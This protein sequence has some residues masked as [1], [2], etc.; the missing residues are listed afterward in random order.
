MRAKRD[1]V[2]NCD[3]SDPVKSLNSARGQRTKRA[4]RCFI[5]TLCNRIFM[6]EQDAAAGLPKPKMFSVLGPGLTTGASDDDPSG[7]AI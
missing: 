1:A 6:T 5:V 4:V 7:I 3:G 2:D